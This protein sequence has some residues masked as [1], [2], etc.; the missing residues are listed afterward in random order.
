[1]VTMQMQA[2]TQGR[3]YVLGL[4]L[5]IASIGWCV[6]PLDSKG[7][8]ADIEALGTFCYPTPVAKVNKGRRVTNR[9]NRGAKRRARHR[10]HHFKAR[11]KKL[12]TELTR[13]G[14][15]PEDPAEQFAF[16]TEKLRTRNG[17]I[18]LSH[19]VALKVKGLTDRLD[20]YELGKIFLHYQRHRGYLSTADLPALLRYARPPAKQVKEVEPEE[21]AELTPEQKEIK[22]L[23]NQIKGTKELVA[24]YGAVSKLQLE[25]I[26]G[27]V[28]GQRAVRA[29][30]SPP[31]RL[32][33][34][35]EDEAVRAEHKKKQKPATDLRF[36]RWMFVEEFDRIWAKQAE[37][38][39]EMTAGL[40]H[41]TKERTGIEGLIFH[42]DPLESKEGD[43]GFCEILHE[44]RVNKDGKESE[45]FRRCRV[46]EMV[47]QR[48]RILTYLVNT[49]VDGRKLT[50]AERQAG[51]EFLIV[52]DKASFAQ[53]REA[54]GLSP[55]SLFKDEPLPATGPKPKGK[56]LVKAAGKGFVSGCKW[57]RQ[58]FEVLSEW[59]ITASGL[60]GGFYDDLVHDLVS[61]G[62]TSRYTA[63]TER[64][65]IPDEDALLLMG[66]DAP[67]GY[68]KRCSRVLRRIEKFLLDP[69]YR[70]PSWDDA[71]YEKWLSELPKKNDD[72][73]PID[74]SSDSVYHATLKAGYKTDDVRRAENA[75][76]LA[77]RL[78]IERDWTTGN[79]SVD[80]AVR[81]SAKVINQVI[82]RFGKPAVIRVELPRRM[83]AGNEERAK[84]FAAMNENAARNEI[85]AKMLEDAHL[86]FKPKSIKMMKLAEE[87]NWRSPYRPDH[88]IGSLQ[89]LIDEYDLDHIVPQSYAAEDGN[90]NLVL[91]PRALNQEKSNKTPW[92]AFGPDDELWTKITGF[93]N[94]CRGMSPGKRRRI[95]AK[96]RPE[97]GMEQR[98]LTQM[99]YVGKQ[100]AAELQKVAPCEFVNGAI[101][102]ELRYR[103]GI[104]SLLQPVK[105][106][107]PEERAI[108]LREAMKK[109]IGK[110]D[111]FAEEKNRDDLRHHAIDAAMVALV[112][113]SL[114]QR[115]TRYYQQL[116]TWRAGKEKGDKPGF[117]LEESF[118][119]VRRR[120]MTL[121][122]SIPVVRPPDRRNA[123]ALHEE[124][125]LPLAEFAGERGV[126]DTFEVR[127][128]YVVRFG[129]EGKV[130]G[131][132]LKSE[133]HHGV[134]FGFLSK[135]LLETVSLFEVSRRVA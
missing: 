58:L 57:G 15:W 109:R 14:W 77:E 127:G 95:L 20:D 68:A 53:L 81:W 97:Q 135:R 125:M 85:Y 75:G 17:Q 54:I 105:A 46:G 107:T 31:K 52:R 51:L 128:R 27:N 129:A 106:E 12:L 32:L 25:I 110:E 10:L 39:P 94:N 100:M 93:V 60:A 98:M 83:A 101:T 3:P 5:G 116:E 55:A 74:W 16:R 67:K 36:D 35:I 26:E 118:P 64:H 9:S 115:L 30:L 87:S 71:K 78:E 119:G 88:H 104:N 72:G 47:F 96:E 126:P 61:L 50:A 86:P 34:K 84:A 1:M 69:N 82:E 40:R 11:R 123:G 134:I 70:K 23:N 44:G 19:P 103:H 114:A 42:Q 48:H 43:V 56:G 7:D 28:M 89:E 132:W 90:F 131:A 91:C 76:E 21:G 2:N 79:P 130:T 133:V 112:D 65:G 99:G 117:E 24:Q 37:F 13:L 122:D 59:G 38:R 120:L 41:G 22:G 4:D 73:K 102:S 124:T 62:E 8:I 121:L 6:A 108:R 29:R 18:E 45:A 111:K 66:L 63:L 92:E 80:A 113:R 33:D 49:S